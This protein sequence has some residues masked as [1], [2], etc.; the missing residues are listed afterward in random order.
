MKTFISVVIVVAIF[1]LGML[2]LGS[3]S[4]KC[5]DKGGVLANNVCYTP[6][7][8]DMWPWD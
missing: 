7:G 4:Q 2:V 1:I 3:T 8:P 6:S 5:M